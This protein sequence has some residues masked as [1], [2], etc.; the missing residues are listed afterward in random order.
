MSIQISSVFSQSP[1][2]LRTIPSNATVYDMEKNELGETPFDMSKLKS[3]NKTIRISKEGYEQVV[4]EFS[5]KPAIPLFPGSV[6]SCPSCNLKIDAQSNN[7]SPTGALAL[8]KKTREH[9]STIMVAIDTPRI[10]IKPLTELGK[11]NSN[12]ILMGDRDIYTLLGYPENMRNTLTGP[13]DDSYLDAYAIST[14]A[15]EKTSL[16]KPKIILKP[17]VNSISFTFKGKLLRDYTGPCS[18]S[19]TWNITDISDT[20]KVL[21]T[22]DITSSIFRFQGNYDLILHHMI[23]ESEKDLLQ[24]DT[25]YSFISRLEVDYLSRSKKEP[26]QLKNPGTKSYTDTREMLREIT[27]SV[28]TIENEDGFGSGSFISG[29]GLILTSYHVIEDEKNIY[30]RYS[31]KEKV[32][33]QVVRVNKDYDLALLK[34]EGEGIKALKLSTENETEVGDEI[35]AAGT[36]LDKSLKQSVTRGIVSGY[37]QWNGV[38]FLQTDVS[39]NS[40][41]SGGPMLNSK[42]EIVG[43]TTMKKVGKGIEGIGFGIPSNVIIEML[44]LQIQSNS[45]KK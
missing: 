21:G 32:K 4:I 44:N 40:G 34:I 33:A 5:A 20:N 18:I 19:C 16:Y 38:N 39:I 12:R 31:N 11:I 35:F 8:R 10:L 27:Q 25:L 26:F 22:V 30:V 41:N 29:D 28:V 14:K 43:I 1:T 37:R 2:V 3:G 42:G 36:P 9:E 6:I 23:Y 24:I 17:R 13:F 7:E 45:P 15:K